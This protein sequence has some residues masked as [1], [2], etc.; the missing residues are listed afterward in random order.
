[1]FGCV[2]RSGTPICRDKDVLVGEIEGLIWLHPD[3]EYRNR[4]QPDDFLG[5]TSDEVSRNSLPAVGRHDNYVLVI[6]LGI[7]GDRWGRI[8]LNNIG[9]VWDAKCVQCF[10]GF[11]DD[12]FTL[13]FERIDSFAVDDGYAVAGR[14]GHIEYLDG[15]VGPVSEFAGVMEHLSCALAAVEGKKDVI[16]H[17]SVDG[18]IVAKRLIVVT[19]I[20]IVT[21]NSERLCSECRTLI[22]LHSKLQHH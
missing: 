21:S 9:A 8:S 16:V 14:I 12:V 1:M 4:G 15:R 10:C 19:D 22:S 13:L 11:L 3:C 18:S 2:C 7:V 17:G 20:S 5:D 6:P